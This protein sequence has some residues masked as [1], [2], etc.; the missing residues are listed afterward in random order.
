MVL[1]RK[2]DNA[3]E[4]KTHYSIRKAVFQDEQ[5]VQ[6]KDDVDKYDKVKACRYYLAFWNGTA[7]GA[8][9]WRLSKAG[10]KLERIC[11]LKE[12]RG[13][14][15]GKALVNKL[16]EDVPKN[17]QIYLGAQDEAVP[18]YEQLGFRVKGNAYW[19]ANILH[20]FM[21]YKPDEPLKVR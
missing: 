5:G 9:R 15:V 21:K 14:G 6:E 3:D 17:I 8:A 2:V 4:L 13:K 11:V 16:L 1:V 12:Y 20:R 18:F 10:H 7:I 19:E